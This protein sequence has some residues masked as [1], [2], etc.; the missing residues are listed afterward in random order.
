MTSSYVIPVNQPFA[1]KLHLTVI[2]IKSINQSIN[3]LVNTSTP[4][5]IPR[6]LESLSE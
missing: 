4:N 2:G 6:I 3:P 1:F 5:R